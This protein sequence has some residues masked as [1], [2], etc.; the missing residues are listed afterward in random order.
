LLLSTK[1]GQSNSLIQ[2]DLRQNPCKSKNL[3]I[4]SVLLRKSQRILSTPWISKINSSYSSTVPGCVFVRQ[5]YLQAVYSHILRKD[6]L[7]GRYNSLIHMGFV[8]SDSSHLPSF[9]SSITTGAVWKSS[10]WGRF[11]YLSLIRIIHI[12]KKC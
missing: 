8:R 4:S 9:S 7:R 5:L 1:S 11:F 12:N 3:N 2:L 10:I 6:V